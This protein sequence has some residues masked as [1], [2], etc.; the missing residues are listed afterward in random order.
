MSRV[1][2]ARGGFTL[3]EVMIAL[4]IL[5]ASLTML[6]HGAASNVESTQRSQLMTAAVELARAKMY[7][8]EEELIAEG[9][10]QLEEKETGDFGD[11]GWPQIKWESQVIRIE[12]PNL[13]SLQGPE[14]EG[15]EGEEGAGG[16]GGMLGGM[17]GGGGGGALIT[18]QFEIFRGILEEA[19]RK[20]TLKVSFTV[21][22]QTEEFTVDYYYTDPTAISRV[23][24]LG[25]GGEDDGGE[26]D[27]GE[28]DGGEDDGGGGG[29]GGGRGNGQL[30]GR[31]GG[32]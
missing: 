2:S 18:S 6:L 15:E 17:F 14:G 11:E 13:E 26:D 16:F 4:A 5:G 1:A 27:G 29:G 10:G 21:A 28:D 22:R 7:D 20:I 12:M 23:I 31:G 25:A 19:I 3:V 9:I 8:I 30:S 32:N 24:Q